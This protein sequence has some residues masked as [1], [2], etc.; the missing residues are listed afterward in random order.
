MD[1]RQGLFGLFWELTNF[2]LR[3]II[4]SLLLK[5]E[6]FLFDTAKKH[7][8]RTPVVFSFSRES[9]PRAASGEKEYNVV[10]AF[11]DAC[12]IGFLPLSTACRRVKAGK[13]DSTFYVL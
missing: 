11:D 2:S 5:R 3:V 1:R 13:S 9:P 8:R 7:M 10:T 6:V 4:I 12:V